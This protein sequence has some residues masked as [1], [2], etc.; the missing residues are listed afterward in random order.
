MCS[1]MRLFV[2]EDMRGMVLWCRITF[3]IQSIRDYI[4]CKEA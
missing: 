3:I 2:L 4:V 1:E